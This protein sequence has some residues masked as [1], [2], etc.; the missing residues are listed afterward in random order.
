MSVI[1]RRARLRRSH[2][3]TVFATALAGSM[4]ISSVLASTPVQNGYRDQAYAGGAFR[5]TAEKPQSKLWF[6]DNQWFAGIFLHRTTPTPTIS[7]FRIYRLNET[8]HDWT[9]TGVKVD[10]RDQ[11]HGDY[12]WNEAT[13]TLWVAS[14]APP[15]SLGNDAIKVFK[16]DYTAGTDAYTPVATFP[17]DIPNTA[18]IPAAPPAAEVPGG[19]YSVTIDRDSSGRLWAVWAMRTEVRYSISD[20]GGATWSVP[21]QVPTQAGNSVRNGTIDGDLASVIAFGGSVGIAWSDHDLLPAVANDGYYFSVIASGQDPTVLANWSLEKLPTL[22]PTANESADNHINIKAASDGTVYMVGKTGKDT[23]GCATNLN[24]PLIEF[25]KRTTAGAWSAHLVGTAGD[26]NTRPQLVISEELDTAWVFLTSP[27]GGGSIYS[28]SAPLTGSDALVF[29][30]AADTTI[31]RGTPFIRSETETAIDDPTTTKQSVTAASG[32]V[33]LANNLANPGTGQQ[34]FY[35]H[36]EMPIAAA[37]STDPVGGTVAIA[38]G[39]AFTATTPV[40][41]SVPATDPGSGVSLVRL[42]N[43]SGTTSGVLTTGT[44]FAYNAAIAW[45]LPGGDGVKTV[46]V[47]WRDAAGN[48][49][50]VSNDT[51]LLDT[52]RPTGTVSINGGAATTTSSNVTLNLTADDGT[53]SGVA[54]VLISNTNDFS[55]ATPIPAAASVPWTLTA[56]DGSRTVYVKWI[57]QAGNVSASPV[58]DS[59]TVDAPPTGSVLINGG[60]SQTNSTSLSLTFPSTSSDATDVRVGTTADLSAATWQTYTGGMTLPFTI[61]AGDGLI[62]VYAQFRDGNAGLS[63][64]VNDTIT[65]DQTAPSG[66]VSINGGAAKTS[67]SNVSLTFPTVAGSPTQVRVG[68]SAD[69]SAVAFQALTPGMTV[70]VTLVAGDGPRTAYAQFLDAA[71]NA[72]VVISDTIEVD[73][74]LDTVPPSVPGR[75]IHR[76]AGAVTTGFPI[77]LNWAAS[78]DNETAVHY[79][80]QQSVNG[81]PYTTI[82]TTTAL[83]V[84][85]QLSSSSKTYR[86]R[87]AARDED[88]NTSAFSTGIAFKTIST[89]ESGAAMKYSGSWPLVAST[90]YIGSKA[91]TSTAKGAS[92]TVTFRGNRIAWLSQR[93]PS[94]GVARIY[95]DGKLKATIDLY[96]PAKAIKQVVYQKAWTAVATRTMRVVVVGGR[97][98]KNKLTVDQFFSVR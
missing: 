71:G 31:Q 56:G 53:G 63:T 62:T 40:V 55:A 23:A 14:A 92:A 13:Q 85:L 26:C 1:I 77:R 59:I 95:I 29:R 79:V 9:D 44:S 94:G 50:A 24:Q 30:G 78:T 76:I 34:K 87:V 73:S 41:V 96:A 88:G 10:T 35:L 82:A 54:S 45:T 32:I 52:T 90:D 5:P 15:D 46:Y 28:K 38:A 47:Q 91:R 67:V 75:L 93:G 17:K 43:A 81:A 48:W 83:I 97:P 6:T 70:P 4:A 8:T 3:L 64:V 19:A 18:T 65:L 22:L 16:Y 25:F 12:L 27:N 60:A 66:T 61:P 21:A 37:D 89:S 2:L 7:E 36:N 49:S 11:T 72:S 39:A 74:T 68:P 57:D 98:G 84:D 42:S 69:L 33:V 20:D 80:L 51:I 86:F 58:S